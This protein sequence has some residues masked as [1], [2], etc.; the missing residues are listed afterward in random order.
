MANEGG[1]KG[2]QLAVRESV[3]ALASHPPRSQ[4]LLPLAALKGHVHTYDG[5]VPW[6]PWDFLDL[7][8]F[9]GI[10]CVFFFGEPM[11]IALTEC[12]RPTCFLWSVNIRCLFQ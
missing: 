6:D 10:S 9:F 5:P 2:V 3:Y 11:N 7:L 12:H 1:G 4:A 8:G